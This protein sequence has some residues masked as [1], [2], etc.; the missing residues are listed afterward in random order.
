MV[1]FHNAPMAKDIYLVKNSSPKF[2]FDCDQYNKF[3][4]NPHC[5]Y[6]GQL[7]GNVQ[8]QIWYRKNNYFNQIVA[9]TPRIKNLL[10]SF[11]KP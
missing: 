1:V 2:F 7:I 8:F 5:F 4:I 9:F 6:Y 3:S 11:I 10:D